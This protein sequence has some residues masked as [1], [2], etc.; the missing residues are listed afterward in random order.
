MTSSFVNFL[1][2][3]LYLVMCVWYA[4]LHCSSAGTAL[5]IVGGVEL[6]VSH[7]Y[8]NVVTTGNGH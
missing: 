3:R 4:R 5:H 8:K 1:V 2:N 7:N 6:S